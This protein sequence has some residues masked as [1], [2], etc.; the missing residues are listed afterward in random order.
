MLDRLRQDAAYALR[1]LARSPV[2]TLTS[3]LSLA[4]GVG[5]NA[6]IFSVASWL[7]LRPVPGLADPG[8][9]VDIGRS[10][11]GSGFDNSSFPNYRDLR[12]RMTT[13]DGVY[14]L[15]TEPQPMSIAGDGQADR[16]Y[17]SIVTA[18]YFETLGVRPLLGRLLRDDDDVAIGGSPVIVLSEALWRRRFGADPAVAGRSIALNGSLFTIVGVAAPGFKG[19]TVLA[20]DL[21]VPMSMLAHASPRM[22]PKIL[23]E[24]GSVWLV[25]G[26]RLKPG[27]TLAQANAEAHAIGA[28]LERHYPSEN[29]GK[30][31]VVAK[32]AI[33]P[34]EAQVVAGFVVLLMTGAGLVLLIACINISGMM[35]ARAAGRQREIAVRLAIGAGR[36]RLIQQ[37]LTETMLLFL[38]GGALGLMLTRWLTPLLISM[39]PELPMPIGIDVVIDWRVVSFSILVSL[40]SALLAGLAPALQSSRADLTAALRAEGLDAGRPRLRLRSAFVVFQVAMSLVLVVAAGLFLRALQRGSNIDPGFDDRN[41]E[42]ISVDLSLARYN[43]QTGNL[44][45]KELLARMR[46]IPGVDVASA[47]VD[48][49]LDGGRI[50][51][52]PLRIPGHAT[53]PDQENFDADWNVVEPGYFSAIRLPLILGRDFSDGDTRGAMDVAIVN[54]PFARV[55]W[56][57]ENP[58]GKQVEHLRREQRV[59]LTIVG[60]TSNAKLTWLTEPQGPV[61]YRPHAQAYLERVRILARTATGRSIVP[62]VRTLLREMS[63][64]LPITSTT[65]LSVMT[66]LNLLPQRIAASVSGTLGLVGLLLAAIGIYGVTSYAVARRT[67][68]IGI[69]IALGA[70]SGRVV[71]L[72]L[73]QGLLL[74][75]IGSLVGLA[76]AAAASQAIESLL[77]GVPGIDPLTFT[78]TAALFTLVA[79][80]ATLVPARRAAAVDPM[81]ALR[82]E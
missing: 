45:L 59:M 2:F 25:M 35:L 14:A 20:P 77:F 70:D 41:V 10:Q 72:V 80:A 3:A 38:I 57:G 58:I 78:A 54:E 16:V 24:R 27:V 49:P 15:R 47:A 44:F 64:N 13:V 71:G 79:L 75:A 28:A 1:T 50:G 7:L 29:R 46:A 30:N 42:L 63:P 19:T 52:G 5:A 55:A 69:R 62:E 17:G 67:R 33:V 81:R 66:G 37:L 34:G 18:N 61:I 73:R 11:N 22:N 9:L 82:Q 51:L 53:P 40:V 43:E 60:V 39:L 76:V 12:A 48:L 31:F 4:I 21:W 23:E 65:T 8:R 74:T 36:G 68:E 26:G 32:S 56:P 6:T